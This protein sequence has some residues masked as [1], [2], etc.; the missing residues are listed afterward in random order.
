MGSP[1]RNL[2]SDLPIHITARSSNRESF[3]LPIDCTWEIFENYLW[4]LAKA[5]NVE[6]FSF[7]LMPN[8]FHLIAKFPRANTSEA[9]MYFMRETSKEI[10][11]QSNRINQVYGRPFHSSVIK[12]NHYF[13][14]AY[15]YVY[16]NCVSA[17]LANLVEE[18]PYSTLSGKL[19]SSR[20][21]IPVVEDTLL[22]DNPFSTLR[23]LNTDFAAEARIEIREALRKSEFGFR[24]TK[25]NALSPLESVLL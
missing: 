19:G 15:K 20:L 4:F 24:R 5:F 9:M 23:W 7:L 16:R 17:G 13:R 18:Y 2:R 25:A 11:K 12:S 10:G 14:Y 1:K 6:I 22:F 21:I 8:H 3:Y